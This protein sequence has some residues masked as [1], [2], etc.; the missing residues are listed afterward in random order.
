MAWYFCSCCRP[1]RGQD[2]PNCWPKWS[3]SPRLWLRLMVVSVEPFVF[4][5]YADQCGPL[6][7]K[8]F[9]C[10]RSLS[11]RRSGRRRET[12]SDGTRPVAK[13]RLSLTASNAHDRAGCLPGCRPTA[14]GPGLCRNPAIAV[15]RPVQNCQNPR[16]CPKCRRS[17]PC[18]FTSGGS[19]SSTT[20]PS[21]PAPP[22]GRRGGGQ[23]RDTC[24]PPAH[25]P[26]HRRR[27]RRP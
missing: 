23:R 8:S 16:R 1:D 10:E 15:G 9:M 21:P 17:N 6:R 26:G 20:M 4:W 18:S 14:C 24:R 27:C 13:A 19:K 11:C 5:T 7:V 22:V 3:R 12:Q 2:L 25:T